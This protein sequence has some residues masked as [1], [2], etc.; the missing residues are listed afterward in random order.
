MYIGRMEPLL[1][2][3][4]ADRGVAKGPGLAASAAPWLEKRE[5]EP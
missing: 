5:A 2:L 1:G 4:L 3:T